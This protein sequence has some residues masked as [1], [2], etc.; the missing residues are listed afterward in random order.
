MCVCALLLLPCFAFDTHLFNS[1]SSHPRSENDPLARAV[2][3]LHQS[4]AQV[5]PF[6]G[7][8]PLVGSKLHSTIGRPSLPCIEQETG[9][10]HKR[11]KTF[12]RLLWPIVVWCACGTPDRFGCLK[13]RSSS[14][15]FGRI[16]F[17]SRPQTRT[18]ES[19]KAGVLLGT[20]QT[21]HT[22]Y[23]HPNRLRPR[24][25]LRRPARTG[26]CRATFFCCR[27]LCAA[28]DWGT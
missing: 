1:R 11:A 26:I 22:N 19:L 14:M 18:T 16:A 21:L 12:P 5:M 17:A 10:G 9:R 15:L 6:I 20:K 3:N 7:C 23:L 28:L 2:S 25:D 13:W 8:S 27:P 4:P 24:L